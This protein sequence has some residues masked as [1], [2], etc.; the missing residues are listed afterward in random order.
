[1]DRIDQDRL[2]EEKLAPLMERNRQLL[3]SQLP[4]YAAVARIKLIFE[5]FE[6]TPTKK[7]KRRLY[8][9]IP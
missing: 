1:M 6:K 4:G 3:N 5:E 7:I 9:M 8:S 2:S